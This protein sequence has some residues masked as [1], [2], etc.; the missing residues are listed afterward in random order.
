MKALL[1]NSVKWNR[2]GKT[3]FRL[4]GIFQNTFLSLN[5]LPKLHY[6]ANNLSIKHHQLD[7]IRPAIKFKTSL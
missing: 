5:K 1:P 4:E 6:F 3:I 7:I 2:K